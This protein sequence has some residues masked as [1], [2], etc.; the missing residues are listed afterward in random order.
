M[1]LINHFVKL[2]LII[3]YFFVFFVLT[4]CSNDTVLRVDDTILNDKTSGS[5]FFIYNNQYILH[6]KEL[7]VFFYIPEIINT[8]TP[9]VF[10]FHGSGRNAKDYRDAMI[11]KANEYHFIVIAPEFSITNF[12]NSDSYN[13]G[14]VFVDGDN[15]STSTL[16]PEEDWTFSVIEPLFDFFKETI[17]NNSS[18]YHIF[19]H[20]AGGQFAHRYVLFKPHA[21]Y[22]HVVASAS[23]WYT[24]TDLNISFPYG[25]FN[26]PLEN[27]SFENLF[28]KNLI[29]QVGNLDNNPNSSGL[30]HNLFADAQGLNRLD[31]AHY[32]YNKATIFANNANLEFNWKFHI[33]ENANHDFRI[34]SINAANLIFN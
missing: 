15:P 13:L 11:N 22:N 25:F 10:V 3:G 33:I 21:R 12:P 5:G 18:T 26:S 19:G 32:F 17:S 31:R 20:S 2:N 24:A 6:E 16:N 28:Q 9:I 1:I 14:N 30:R 7:K 23:G 34:A 4:M 29:I 27:I 8:N